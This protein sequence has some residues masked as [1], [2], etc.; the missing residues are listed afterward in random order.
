MKTSFEIPETFEN[1]QLKVTAVKGNVFI[2]KNPME[3]SYVKSDDTPADSL[4]TTFFLSGFPGKT[5]EIKSVEAWVGDKM[6][7]QGICDQQSWQIG[8]SGEKFTIEARSRGALLLDNEALPQVY[9]QAS[10]QEIFYRHL[11]P[12]GFQNAIASKSRIS[13]C[14][15]KGMNEWE[16]FAGFCQRATGKRPYVQ[17]NQVLISR[18]SGRIHIIDPQVDPVQNM[19]YRVRRFSVISKVLLRDEEG[20]YSTQIINQEAQGLG[21][22]RKR[23]LIPSP[24]WAQPTADADKKMEQSME[25]R[26]GWEV[27]LAGF[28]DWQL[29]EPAQILGHETIIRTISEVQHQFAGKGM[30]T[31]VFLY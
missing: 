19:T 9:V 27:E 4:K 21:I 23:Y 3:F 6:I 17:G 8:Q 1:L 29:G 5:T 16:V 25:H 7:F 2:L 15:T 28:F 24:Q 20:C 13:F 31:K 10:P 18:Q 14:V 12:Y 26:E 22:E 11:A 30:K